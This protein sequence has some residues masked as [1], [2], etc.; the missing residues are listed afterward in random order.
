MRKKECFKC[1]KE[2]SITQFYR[3]P[4]MG[5]GRLGKCKECTKKDV[6]ENYRANKPH[7]IEYEKRRFQKYARKIAAKSYQIKRRKEKPGRYK[8]Q[9]TVSNAIRDGRLLRK[10]CEVCKN[11]KSQAHHDDYRKPL[12]V[13]WLCRKHHLEHHGKIAY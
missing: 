13:R 2:K 10:P 1:S 8:A 12:V 4:K 5:D 9:T 7:Y 6:A 3:H 11:V